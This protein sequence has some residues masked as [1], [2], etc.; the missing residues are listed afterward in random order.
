MTSEPLTA[1][2]ARSAMLAGIGLM[3][4]GIFL[5]CCNDALGKWILGTYSVAQMILI[6]STVAL[7][8][9]APFIWRAG[10]AAFKSAPRPGLQIARVILSTLEV[11]MFFWAVSYLPLA[12]TVTFYLASPIYVTALSALFLGERVGWRRWSAVL[13][14]FAGVVIALRPSAAMLTLPA[15]IALAGSF[16]FALLMIT[17]RMLRGTADIVLATGQIGT[18]FLFGLVAA[19]FAWIAPTA[20]DVGLMAILGVVAMMALA[21]VNRSLKLAPA[22][23]VAPYQYTMIVWAVALGLAVF[24]DVPD[25]AMA[26]GAAIIVTAGL[27]IFWRE[28]IVAPREPGIAPPPG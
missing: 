21:C 14:G 5:F 10:R 15:L 16:F 25:I 18:T 23:V 13:F 12:D 17:T 4:L 27:Y 11:V 9:L 2:P 7:L 28:Q 19:P 22:S 8:L 6:R 26:V 20:I 24:G 1:S 3:L